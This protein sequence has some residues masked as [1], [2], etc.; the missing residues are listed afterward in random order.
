MEKTAESFRKLTDTSVF[1]RAAHAYTYRGR[2][3]EE[4]R[5]G[6]AYALHLFLHGEGEMVIGGRTYPVGKG[7]LVFIRP[8]EVHA[9]HYKPGHPLE[10]YNI[11]FDLWGRPEP[12]KSLYHL[13]FRTDRV[14]PSLLTRIE[15]CP[16]LE[17]LPTHFSVQP[18]SPLNEWFIQICRI[19]EGSDE[20]AERLTANLLQSWLLYAHGQLSSGAPTDKRLKPILERMEKDPERYVPYDELCQACGLEKTQFY[21]LFRSVTGM[22]P[23]AY[24]LKM[25]MRKAA[26]LL[27]ES[28]ESVTGISEMLGYETVHY[29]SKQ[30][31]DSYG[32]PPSRYRSQSRGLL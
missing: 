32:I 31:A 11:Y 13:A 9:F 26:A 17:R 2:P 19:H 6:F 16:D 14:H 4:T 10:A 21:M 25:K 30:F 12:E 23:K 29:F 5:V 18:S 28:D 15:P 1:I 8:G 22:S 7:S 27:L 20:Y 3:E 24:Q